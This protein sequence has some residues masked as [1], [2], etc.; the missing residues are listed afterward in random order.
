M[1]YFYPLALSQIPSS[2]HN[3]LSSLSSFS[4]LF[5]S[6]AVVQQEDLGTVHGMPVPYCCGW[7]IPFSRGKIIRNSWMQQPPKF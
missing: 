5:F 6:W 2:M 4:F 1:F 3:G 7:T